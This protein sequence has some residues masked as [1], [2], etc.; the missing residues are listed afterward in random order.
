M[1]THHIRLMEE[2]QKKLEQVLKRLRKRDATDFFV[3][4]IEE[5]WLKVN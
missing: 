2:E 5:Y 4:A 1:K 3:S